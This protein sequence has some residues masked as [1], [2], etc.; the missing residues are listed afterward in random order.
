MSN[1]PATELSQV[2]AGV[3]FPAFSKFQTDIK[4]LRES[5]LVTI[6]MVSF[7]AVPMGLGFA[8]VTPA[9]VAAAFGPEWLPMVVAMQVLALYGVYRAIGKTMGA[10]WKAV[11]RPDYI[12]KTSLIKVVIIAALIYPVTARWGITGTAVLV[13]AVNLLVSMPLN[14]YITAKVLDTTSA[15]ILSETMY[16]LVAS[17]VMAAATWY[18]GQVLVL[19]AWLEL[20]AMIVTG[21]VVYAAAVLALD[22]GTN[23][24]MRANIK[25]LVS[26]VVS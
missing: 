7:V 18:V 26:N 20:C 9:F 21:G 10:L 1:A 16:P 8:V 15:R 11:G 19:P 5:Y 17:T 2:I 23:W 24:G 3:M 6:R 25:Q 12:T 22:I 4:R 13:L 14:L